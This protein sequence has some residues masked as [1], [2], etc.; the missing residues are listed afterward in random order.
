VYNPWRWRGTRGRWS[1]RATAAPRRRAAPCPGRSR[2][3][4]IHSRCSCVRTPPALQHL[5]AVDLEPAGQRSDRKRAPDRMRVQHRA[6]VAHRD[7]LECSRVS[8]D[9]DPSPDTTVPSASSVRMSPASAHPCA[10]RC[11]DRQPQRIAR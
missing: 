8:A 7:D 10:S 11:G 9:G 5:V 6:G 2:A 3:T 1:R 4:G